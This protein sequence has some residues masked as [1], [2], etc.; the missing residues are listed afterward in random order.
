MSDPLYDQLQTCP[1]CGVSSPLNEWDCCGG[2]NDDD[3]EKDILW[4]P[5]CGAGST[6]AEH[7]HKP[8]LFDGATDLDKLQTAEGVG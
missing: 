3:L 1:H 2:M 4:C 7:E 8:S 5:E 6:P